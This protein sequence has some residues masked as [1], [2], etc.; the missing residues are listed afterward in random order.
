MNRNDVLTDP[1]KLVR[2]ELKNAGFN[3]DKIKIPERVYLLADDIF[4]EMVSRDAGE[5]RYPLGGKLYVF[6]KN[7]NIGFIKGHMCSPAIATQA[8]DLIAG[9][10]KELIHV[11]Y[12]GGLQPELVPGEIILTDG[13][14][15][16]TAVAKLYGYDYELIRSSKDLTNKIEEMI[17][18]AE[19]PYKRG[20]HWTTDAGYRETWGQVMDYRDKGALCVEMEGVGLFT[21]ANYRKC[22]AT[23]IYVV[24]DVYSENDWKLGWEGNDIKRAVGAVI[25]MIIESIR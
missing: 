25:D 6:N 13:A 18:S 4:D 19:I 10:V 15:N 9:G 23:G 20:L 24:S 7:D 2:V 17:T 12:A 16:D 22:M 21:I 5:Y 14:F 1:K 8:E 3:I 11:G